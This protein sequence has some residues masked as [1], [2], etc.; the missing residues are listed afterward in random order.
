MK[1]Q[2]GH[3]PLTPPS[4]HVIGICAQVETWNPKL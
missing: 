4:L 1:S 3:D 2:E